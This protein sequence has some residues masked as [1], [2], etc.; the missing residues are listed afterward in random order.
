[1][2]TS[3][4]A[5]D[6]LVKPA[7]TLVSAA[8]A[9]VI[10]Y[11]I[12]SMKTWS[13][14]TTRKPWVKNSLQHYAY[15]FKQAYRR[16]GIRSFYHGLNM[17]VARCSLSTAAVLGYGKNVN[18]KLS[19][20][21]KMGVLTPA[22]SKT[23]SSFIVSMIS[24]G[25]LVPVD[26]IKVRLQADGRKHEDLRR[27][28]GPFNACSEFV[29][30]NGI[31]ALWNGSAPMLAR[32]T[33]WWT[34]SIPVYNASKSL[35]HDLAPFEKAS[36]H[37]GQ[38]GDESAFVHIIASGLSGLAATI[39]SHPFDVIRT[40]LANQPMKNPVYSGMA[41]CA[42]KV[43]ENQGIVGLFKGFLPRYGRLGPF[44]LIFW[45]VYEKALVLATGENFNWD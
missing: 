37:N 36:K 43:V 19:Y 13:Q 42:L 29:K 45:C 1:M 38:R 10:L 11:P 2:S 7:I 30:R 12:D 32:S 17:S 41:D 34:T 20:F 23:F 35:L 28:T 21:T 9:E 18:T 27:Y 33:M 40:K 4:D 14:T 25:M 15:I 3:K 39:A 8:T 5:V 26:T 22:V 31:G 44:Q 24:N 6:Y 16:G